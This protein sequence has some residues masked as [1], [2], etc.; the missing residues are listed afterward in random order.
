MNEVIL[1]LI[2]IVGIFSAACSVALIALG[3]IIDNFPLGD[4]ET[5][6]RGISSPVESTKLAVILFWILF[7]PG[8]WAVLQEGIVTRIVGITLLFSICLFMFTGLVFSFAVLSAMKGRKNTY[9]D[10]VL[11]LSQP[12]TQVIPSTPVNVKETP[13]RPRRRE[14]PLSNVMVHAL[15]K[16]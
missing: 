11:R 12:V 8:A 7:I 5:R 6:N 15:L 14:N 4:E 13:V 9:G 10:T 1:L 3:K 16:K 2:T